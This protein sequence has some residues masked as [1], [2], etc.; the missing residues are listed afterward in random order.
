MKQNIL[1]SLSSIEANLYSNTG[2][3]QLGKNIVKTQD[4]ICGKLLSSIDALW[5]SYYILGVFAA[6][7]IP[8]IIW[9]VNV[10]FASAYVTVTPLDEGK[11]K[12]SHGPKF[13]P[14]KTAEY[15]E[16]PGTR[17]PMT[18]TIH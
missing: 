17:R 13:S 5:L 11:F 15:N 7:S 3:F 14:L 18:I 1:T 6:I 12:G 2:C 8:V 10:I 16:E 4:A 9:S